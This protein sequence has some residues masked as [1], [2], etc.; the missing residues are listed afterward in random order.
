MLAL[1]ARPAATVKEST[2][3]IP[4]IL[5][6]HAFLSCSSCALRCQCSGLVLGSRIGREENLGARHMKS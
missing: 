5:L 3:P 2:S 1:W 6:F 4:I